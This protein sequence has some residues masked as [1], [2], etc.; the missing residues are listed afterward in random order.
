M[1]YKTGDKVIITGN[2]R[3]FHYFPI[4]TEC[5]IIYQD[6]A[7]N[8]ELKGKLYGRIKTQTVQPTDFKLITNTTM[9]TLYEQINYACEHGYYPIVSD[10]EKY[11][12]VSPF[13]DENENWRDSAPRTVLSEAIAKI[14]EYYGDDEQDWNSRESEGYKITGYYKPKHKR[15]EAGEKV[16]VVENLEGVLKLEVSIKE[17]KKLAGKVCEIKELVTEG[18]RVYTPLKNDWFFLPQGA[19]EPYFE[20]KQTIKVG[21]DEYVVT[22]ELL[23]A[24]KGLKKV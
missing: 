19:L 18:Y 20:P 22:D 2:T 15:F 10:G 4:G 11:I 16:R 13:K 1:N 23:D 3:G 14:G 8:Y 24:L 12:I 17:L 5:E 21:D 7:G 9:N 6:H